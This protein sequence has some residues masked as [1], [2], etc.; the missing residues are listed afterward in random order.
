MGDLMKPLLLRSAGMAAL[1]I[2]G[3]TIGALWSG[4]ASGAA[5]DA[6]ANHRTK[7]RIASRLSSK[8]AEKPKTAEKTGKTPVR[9]PRKVIRV[10]SAVRVNRKTL[11]QYIILH[12][13]VWPEVLDRMRRSNIRNYSIYLGE[14]D[15]GNLYLFSYLEYVGDDFD[16]DMQAVADDP[17]S[18]EWWKLT[19]PLQKRIKNTPTGSQ[20][21]PLTEIFHVD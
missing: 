6:V 1:V 16:G 7:R 9:K 19:D 13:H 18:R 14:M 2:L 12:R 5:D 11:D 20:W 15:D 4:M 17:A 8:R 3:V 10:G 21:K